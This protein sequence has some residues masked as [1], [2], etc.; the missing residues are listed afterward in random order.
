[1]AAFFL[2]EPVEWKLVESLNGDHVG[3]RT[4]MGLKG[5]DPN[6]PKGIGENQ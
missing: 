6:G 5:S 4:Q 2:G 1:M 3:D